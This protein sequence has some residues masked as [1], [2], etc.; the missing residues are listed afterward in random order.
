MRVFL[1]KPQFLEYLGDVPELDARGACAV[2]WASGLRIP[3]RHFW[4][5]NADDDSEPVLLVENRT[6][7]NGI[8]DFEPAR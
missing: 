8:P 1:N 6:T 4:S 5:G 3:V 7:V 2:T